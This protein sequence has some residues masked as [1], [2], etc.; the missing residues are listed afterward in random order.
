MTATKPSKTFQTQNQAA[1]RRRKSA[2]TLI[3]LLVVIAIIAILAALLLPALASTKF[4][5]KVSNCTSNSKQWG[6]V[7]NLYA[8]D[9]SQGHLPQIGPFV[10]TYLWDV[11][12]NMIPRLGRYGLTV[13]MWFDPVRPE[14]LDKL[15]NF[16][17]HPISTIAD[18]SFAFTNNTYS[19]AIIEHNYWVPRP[20]PTLPNPQPAWMQNTPVGNYGYPA[21]P[22]QPSWN[23]VPFITCKA[24]SSTDTTAGSGAKGLLG[25]ITPPASGT[26]S[27]NP[28]DICPNSA[29]FLN[30]VCQGVNATY[31]DGHV[32]MHIQKD[33]QCGYQ[34]PGAQIF[35]FY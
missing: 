26:A 18:L 12:P 3:E 22:G 35:W 7:A 25:T 20:F 15:Q 10:G 32:E 4:R 14:E 30:G 27:S 33:M 2:F 28:S 8:N 17:G 6:I 9:D 11:S 24:I 13:A 29:H 16:Y 5:A 1:R 34:I 31:G 21:A 23:Q 19:E